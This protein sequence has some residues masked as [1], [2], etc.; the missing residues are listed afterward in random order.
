MKSWFSKELFKDKKILFSIITVVLVLAC[1]LCN[2]YTVDTF[3]S[4]IYYSNS[5]NASDQLHTGDV[6]EQEFTLAEGDEGV[7]VFF[8]TYVT[9]LQGGSVQAELFDSHGA[10]VS[11]IVV[12]LTGTQDNTYVSFH[13]GPLDES[14]YNTKCK[15]RLTFLDLENQLLAYYTAWTDGI[16][17]CTLNGEPQEHNLVVNGIRPTTYVE[18]RDYRIHYVFGF[19]IFFAYLAIFKIKWKEIDVK[20]TIDNC[21]TTLK[22][23]NW[24]TGLITVGLTVGCAIAAMLS[25]WYAA[26]DEAYVNPYRAFS[27]FTALFIIAIAIYYKKYIWQRAHI[28]FFVVSMLV[29]SVYTLSAPPTPIG[30]DEQLHYSRTA[31]MAMG[32][33]NRILVPDYLMST[34]YTQKQYYD[35]FQKEQREAWVIEANEFDEAGGAMPYLELVGV[36]FV[37]YIPT[38]IF[39]YVTRILGIDFI[40][41][42]LMGKIFNLFM[43]SAFLATAIKRLKGRG[44]MIVAA[45]ALTPTN[46][47]IASSYGYDWWIISLIILGYATIIGE[48]QEKGVAST[49]T[50][51]KSVVF[52][53]LGLMAKAVYFPLM[54]PFMLL[55]KERYENSKKARLTVVLGMIF[56]IISFVLPMFISSS[57]GAVAGG[58]DIR[59]G[60]DVNAAGQISY[61]LNNFEEFF[62][63]LFYFVKSYL[64]PDSASGY[65]TLMSYQGK[66]HYYTVIQMILM[67]AAVVDND[68][69][70]AFGKK[71]TLAKCGGYLGVLGALVLAITAMYV[72]YT[73][74]GASGVSGC[75]PRY[76]IPVL[77]PFLFF[78]G[79]NKM[80]IPS[81]SK[82]KIYSWMVIVMA[83]IV[84]RAVYYSF[85]CRY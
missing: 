70:L 25:E 37:S 8:G 72:A 6:I 81:E 40:S 3:A 50:V 85:G 55:R 54:L 69:D 52:M 56:L 20:K 48:L 82:G 2:Y 22:T 42:Y 26:L 19:A 61:I 11:E 63:M 76:A 13:F 65:L 46:I 4:R 38:S 35:I 75:Q 1:I 18:Y 9:V 7:Q 31:Y 83:I 47:L 51:V 59:G 10:K 15:I 73:A 53:C 45:V 71:E 21:K 12:D 78:F 30:W 84:L 77:F 58:G 80:K 68:E 24:K 28:F 5:S 34:M 41:R 64:H 23:I 49:R 43:Y 36:S 39:L 57:T 14:L 29:G 74:V 44:K 79:E 67:A 27:T 17:F 16:T 32:A 60:S 62:M 66:G 33:T